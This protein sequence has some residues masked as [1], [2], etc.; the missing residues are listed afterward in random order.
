MIAILYKL[1]TRHVGS[2]SYTHLDVYKRQ[3]FK[4]YCV[5]ITIIIIIIIIIIIV[6]LLLTQGQF[7]KS[8]ITTMLTGLQYDI[9][10]SNFV[11]TPFMSILKCL[12]F[13]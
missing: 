12:F 3:L 7:M 10:K 2:V 11:L 5:T 1:R 8:E 13:L 4:E 9:C 6:L